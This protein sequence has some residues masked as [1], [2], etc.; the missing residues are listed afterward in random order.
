MSTNK[1]IFITYIA[2]LGFGCEDNMK[3]SGYDEVLLDDVS[4]SLSEPL[5][6]NLDSFIKSLVSYGIDIEFEPDISEIS[7]PLN[8]KTALITY[9]YYEEIEK[10]NYSYWVEENVTI[11]IAGEKGVLT[12]VEMLYLIHKSVR[13]HFIDYDSHYF[14]G[15]QLLDVEKNVPEYE[16]LLGS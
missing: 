4:W 1:F 11:S 8:F 6:P 10:D 13:K 2:F 7:Q 12:E 9:K 14:E 16:V 3:Q 5:S 15:L